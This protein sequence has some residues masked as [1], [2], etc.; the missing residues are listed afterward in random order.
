M[1]L[2]HLYVRGFEKVMS[3]AREV[4]E[5]KQAAAAA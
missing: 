2:M 3:R 5:A 4:L 1:E